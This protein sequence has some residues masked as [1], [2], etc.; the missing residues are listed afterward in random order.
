MDYSWAGVDHRHSY[1]RSVPSTD[2]VATSSGVS[3]HVRGPLG[4]PVQFFI[5]DSKFLLYSMYFI[6]FYSN[7][8]LDCNN[9][10][11]FYL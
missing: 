10:K 4:A 6:R 1:L 9:K 8:K 2:T 7:K 5:L 3:I 11:K